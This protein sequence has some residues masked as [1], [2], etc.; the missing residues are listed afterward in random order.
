MGKRII[1]TILA[2]LSLSSGC[3]SGQ[4]SSIT[5]RND[6]SGD[7]I[8]ID[9]ENKNFQL[10]DWGDQ[11]NSCGVGCYEGSGIGWLFIGP[12]ENMAIGDTLEFGEIIFEVISSEIAELCGS[13][14][15]VT[16]MQASVI[17]RGIYRPG[18][19]FELDETGQLVA[20]GRY[21]HRYQIHC[22]GS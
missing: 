4:N 8:S 9:L 15:S 16:G 22:D 7:E 10:D 2:V 5:Y 18:T 20:F 17:R 11:L 3:D 21:P 19:Y 13:H 6:H 1:V 12:T 14:Q